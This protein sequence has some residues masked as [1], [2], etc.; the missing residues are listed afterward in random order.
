MRIA[1]ITHFFPPGHI[2]G[3]EVLT[4]NLAT[5]LQNA[6]HTV[7]VICAEDWTTARS[8]VIHPVD[9]IYQGVPVRRL[10]FN[11][12]KAPDVFGYLYNNPEV[13]RYLATFLERFKPDVVHVTSCYSLS[14]S[15]ISAAHRLGLP[16]ILTATDFWFLCARNTLL[17]PDGSLCDG[18]TDSWKCNRCMASDTKI[19]RWSGKLL[20]EVA[21]AALIRQVSRHAWLTSQRGLRGMIGD[22]EARTQFLLQS[23]AKVD[24]IITASSFLRELFITY[25]VAPEKIEVSAYGLDTTWARGYETKT[26]SDQL[27]IGFIGQIIPSKGPDILL[28]AVKNLPDH[29]P[30][31]VVIYGNLDKE[32]EYGNTLRKLADNDPRIRFAGT[33]DNSRMGDV[34]TEIDALVVPSIWYDFPLVVSSALA[35]KTPVVATDLPGMNELITHEQNGLLFSR[36]NWRELAAQITRLIVEPELLPRLRL[37]IDPVKTVDEMC[38]E[39][40]GRYTALVHSNV[41]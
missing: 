33:F 9:D 4:T 41:A 7:Q 34:L 17:Q 37:G 2:G 8:H 40:E 38:E 6:G 31:R 32:P 29:L 20:P 14:A 35:T 30:V 13:E 36:N 11:W 16:I 10:R 24:H 15:V 1:L 21:T 27:R 12:M 22:W 25:G 3:T 19:Y 5:S 23:L 26:P 39:Y 18:P 28:R